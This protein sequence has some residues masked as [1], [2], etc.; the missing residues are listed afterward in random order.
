[1]SIES[2]K[3]SEQ[4]EAVAR[5]V[6]PGGVMSNWR[7]S[8]DHHPIFMSHGRGGRLYDVDGNEYL[9]FSLSA[10]PAIL[11]HDNGHLRQAIEKQARCTTSNEPHEIQVTAAQ[12]LVE[13]IACADLVRFANSG[14]EANFNALRVARAY[15]GR[16]FF[17]RFNGH[18]NGSSDSLIGGIVTDPAN[19]VPV[20]EAREG[21][22]LSDMGNTEG[23]ARHGFSDSYML[24]WNDLEA[25]ETLLRDKGG[26]IA[27]VLM[28]PVMVNFSGCLPEPG[29]LEGVRALCDRH[30]VVL[31][32]DE[33]LTGFRMGLGGAQAHFGVTPD[34]T[35]LGKA[36]GGG[37]PVSAYCGKR[38]IMGLIAETRVMG[39]GTY[40]GH[41][42]AMAAVVATLEELEKENGA[43]YRRIEKLGNRLKTGLDTLA[44]ER[45]QDLLLQGFPG[46]WAFTFS[47][48]PKIINH[49]DSL[50]PTGGLEKAARFGALLKEQ[51]VLTLFRFCTSVA[52]TEEDIDE[53]LTR[54]DAALAA[55]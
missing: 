45:G 55:L 9:D 44:R 5:G 32:F 49:R 23:R 16:N 34:L 19:P 22:L 51:G 4:I 13:H 7:K 39:G 14:T 10:G 1:M 6:I 47:T 21:D 41:P 42:M 43:A 17:V 24:E 15:T 35:I 40:N 50:V 31:I 53:A 11:G 52:H 36:I 48:K 26:D 54:S 38:E 33:V 28:E 25:L 27:A 20:A 2:T 30:G 8:E 37:F 3:R 12:K 46:A 18:Y 29:Y